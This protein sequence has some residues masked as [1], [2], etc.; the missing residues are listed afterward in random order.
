MNNSDLTLIGIAAA[1]LGFVVMKTPRGTAG[2]LTTA[3]VPANAA[4]VLRVGGN[5]FGGIYNTTEVLQPNGA[6][7]SNG[8]QYFS[9]GTSISPDG[10]YYLNG[11]LQYDP[12]AL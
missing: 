3:G 8:W 7:W 6:S 12:T 4:P 11:A 5:A 1:V 10:K 9:D 2:S